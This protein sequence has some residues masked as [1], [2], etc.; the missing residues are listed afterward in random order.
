M[1]SKTQQQMARYNRK[2]KRRTAWKR[3]VTCLS[4]VV[5]FVTTYMLILPAITMETPTFCG[6]EAHV[7]D[8][9]CYV[10]AEEN[11]PVLQCTTESLGLHVHD[12][13]CYD[14]DG[15][16]LCGQAD[17]VIHSHNE[18]C[19][20]SQGNRVCTLPETVQHVHAENCYGYEGGH[21]HGENCY[22]NTRGQ[23]LCTVAEEEG[24]A[25][26]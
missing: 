14:E 18:L 24:H 19:H 6:I 16:V 10:P 9:G 26:L 20:D 11:Q 7:H 23:L 21:A 17:Y 8:N 1:N 4:A 25:P 5:V 15:R 3:V 13:A 22:T 12:D 2:H